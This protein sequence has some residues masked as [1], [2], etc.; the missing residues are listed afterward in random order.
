M[1]GPSRQ[2]F[3]RRRRLRPLAAHLPCHAPAQA[4]RP[5]RCL[6]VNLTG[7]WEQVDG[8]RLDGSVLDD[9]LRKAAA[10]AAAEDSTDVDFEGEAGWSCSGERALMFG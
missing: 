5:A 2:K 6:P 10:A 3:R 4:A 1:G 9:T 7:V 8:F